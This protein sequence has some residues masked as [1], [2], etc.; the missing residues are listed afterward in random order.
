MHDGAVLRTHLCTLETSLH[1]RYSN[2][3]EGL[4][5]GCC[6]VQARRMSRMSMFI[7]T[8]SIIFAVLSIIFIVIWHPITARSLIPLWHLIV[9]CLSIAVYKK[10]QEAANLNA[11]VPSDTEFSIWSSILWILSVEQI[12]VSLGVAWVAMTEYKWSD[13]SEGA[14]AFCF[15]LAAVA[16]LA[17]A[18][19]GLLAGTRHLLSNENNLVRVSVSTI[20]T[21]CDGLCWEM[22]S[23]VCAC[24]HGTEG[25]N[26]LEV[27]H[28]DMWLLWVAIDHRFVSVWRFWCLRP[29]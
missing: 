3:Q 10:A 7:A 28:C 25:L 12:I 20:V 21:H 27:T 24:M 19:M 1:V 6:G 26:C 29:T 2:M 18:G 22:S 14:A 16:L 4:Q 13:T 17:A 15:L 11:V 5:Q 8:Q 23:R 9:A